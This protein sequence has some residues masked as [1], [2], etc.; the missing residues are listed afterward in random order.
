MTDAEKRIIELLELIA[1]E[2]HYARHQRCGGPIELGNYETVFPP[3][4][5]LRKPEAE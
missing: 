2:L 3:P 1:R 4:K 5:A